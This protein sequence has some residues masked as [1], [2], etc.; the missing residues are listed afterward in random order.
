VVVI[1]STAVC[2]EPLGDLAPLQPP[3]AVQPVALAALQV[4]VLV[5]PAAT[6]NGEADNTV[7][8]TTF[9]VALDGAPVPPGPVHVST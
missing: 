7:V 1:A 6:T 8:G 3:D 4:S 5:L 9:T 2:A